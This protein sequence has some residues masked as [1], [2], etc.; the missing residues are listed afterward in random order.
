MNRP[1][2]IALLLVTTS[3]LLACSSDDSSTADSGVS[4]PLNPAQVKAS[5]EWYATGATKVIEAGYSANMLAGLQLGAQSLSFA[6]LT[7]AT[8]AGGTKTATVQLKDMTGQVSQSLTNCKD[9]CSGT[10]CDFKGCAV[11]GGAVASGRLSWTG[12]N[13]KC[14]GLT[15]EDELPGKSGAPSSKSKIVLECDLKSSGGTLSGTA[16]GTVSASSGD[17]Q[18][19]TTSEIQIDV[20]HSAVDPATERVT[21]KSGSARASATDTLSGQV[22]RGTAEVTFP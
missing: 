22:Y 14:E 10:V 1:L 4:G 13:V 12:G 6:A 9:A 21:I 16:K 19:L 17:V 20:K 5:V 2:A 7:G 8:G 3:G 15:I 11:G 18:T